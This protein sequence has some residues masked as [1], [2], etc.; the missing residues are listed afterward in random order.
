M[1]V[2]LY[3]ELVM[4]STTVYNDYYIILRLSARIK[5]DCI[6]ILYPLFVLCV[7]KM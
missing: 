5:I 1:S 6:E 2:L 7:R 3:N 4:L